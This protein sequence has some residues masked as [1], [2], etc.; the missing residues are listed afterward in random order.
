MTLKKAWEH[1]QGEFLGLG[2][3]RLQQSKVWLLDV[4]FGIRSITSSSS[5]LNF[6]NLN[7]QDTV[8]FEISDYSSLTLSSTLEVSTGHLTIALIDSELF[9]NQSVI[10]SSSTICLAAFHS[11]VQLMMPQFHFDSVNFNLSI[12]ELVNSSDIVVESLSCIDC[13]VLGTHL[14]YVNHSSYI[15]S[16]KFSPFILVSEY[17]QCSFITGQVYLTHSFDFYSHVILDDVSVSEFLVSSGSIICHSDVLMRNTVSISNVSFV[18]KDT[19]SLFDTIFLFDPLLVLFDFQTMKGFGTIDTNIVNS[20]IIRPS[21][22]FKFNDNL[23]LSTSSIICIQINNTTSYDHLIVDLTSFLDGILELEFETNYDSTGDNYTLI[24]SGL[25]NGKFSNIVNP[26]ASLITPFYSETSLI[27]SVNDYVVDLNQI[28]YI[29]PSG[30]DDPCCGTFDSPCA[31]FRGVLERMGRKGKV[32]FH[33]GTYTFDQGLGIV[34]DV[35]WEV[36]GLGDVIIDGSDETLFDIVSSSLTF[37]NLIIYGNNVLFEVFNSSIN[38]DFVSVLS[39]SNDSMFLIENSSL[40]TTNCLFDIES[41][42]LFECLKS[43]VFV[44]NSIFSG[45]LS[46]SLISMSSS[47]MIADNTIFRYLN[48]INLVVSSSSS[49]EFSHSLIMEIT[50]NMIFQLDQSDIVLTSLNCSSVFSKAFVYSSF[51]AFVL[52]AVEVDTSISTMWF[53]LIN[54]TFH[55]QNLNFSSSDGDAFSV[56]NSTDSSLSMVLVVNSNLSHFLNVLNSGLSI[57]S[58]SLFNCTGSILEHSVSS[59]ITTQNLTITDSL[60]DTL[61]LLSDSSLSL[62]LGNIGSSSFNNSTLV[63]YNST[64]E[65]EEV[66]IDL[67]STSIFLESIDSNSTFENFV[68]RNYEFLQFLVLTRS[69]TNFFSLFLDSCQLYEL[70]LLVYDITLTESYLTL[71]KSNISGCASNQDF[72]LSLYSEKSYLFFLNFDQEFFFSSL[73]LDHSNITIISYFPVISKSVSIDEE[74]I[75]LGNAPLLDLSRLISNVSIFPSQHCC[76]TS[77]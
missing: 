44:D 64:L 26:C 74:S 49:I 73:V 72:K 45:S 53:S 39:V 30:I 23:S 9:F 2:E 19:L 10:S 3:L 59:S 5:I 18:F 12:L 24:E 28:S 58:L 8:L 77:F 27:V 76:N 13:F 15:N 11:F 48:V 54:C 35:D 57:N 16:G 32:Y 68:I 38:F 20:G 6:D 55:L 7:I 69:K 60:F 1:N 61:F 14:L 33:E 63:L 50:A 43:L 41:F 34:R 42:R 70:N 65:M 66:T 21:P 51:G 71:K 56:V 37:Q 36:I 46:D 4:V 75:I 47:S 17:A 29:S 25:I 62:S 31:S 52:N 67:V 40:T 22:Y